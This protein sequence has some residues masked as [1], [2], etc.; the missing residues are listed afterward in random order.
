VLGRRERSET[1]TAAAGVATSNPIRQ[2]QPVT[3]QAPIYV[4]HSKQGSRQRLDPYQRF[5]PTLAELV[6][7]A[8]FQI[9]GI[10]PPEAP[11]SRSVSR[12][13][14]HEFIP[15]VLDPKRDVILLVAAP[16]MQL[17]DVSVEKFKKLI[18]VF[19]GIPDVAFFEFNPLTE[20]VKGLEMPKS[21]NP[22]LSIW[23][24]STE[25]RGAAFAAFLDLPI[26]FDNLLKLIALKPTS[27]QRTLMSTRV[28]KIIDH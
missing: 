6:T 28:A 4:R 13:T 22:Q 20:H 27:Q 5:Q 25:Q 16:R 21:D 1:I 8:K 26:M 19:D 10:P 17:Y 15:V 7:W 23:P 12:I 24:A 18:E 3:F 2:L 9:M 11:H 14:A